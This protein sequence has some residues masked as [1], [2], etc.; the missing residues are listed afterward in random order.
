[1]VGTGK[2]CCYCCW[3]LSE[4][5]KAHLGSEIVLNT[6]VEGGS[7]VVEVDTT[8][9]PSTGLRFVLEGTHD[10]IHEWGVPPIGVPLEFLRELKEKLAAQLEALAFH[11]YTAESQVRWTGEAETSG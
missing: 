8:L 7:G 6:R 1:M 2:R 5:L 3:E 10:I 9:L 4:W 11:W